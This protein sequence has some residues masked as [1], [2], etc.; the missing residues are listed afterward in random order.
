MYVAISDGY[1][2]AHGNQGAAA[3][4]TFTVDATGPAAPTFAPADGDTAGPGTEI[5]LTFAEALRKDAAGAE[6]ANT[7]LAAILTLKTT[8]ASGTDIA[9]AASIDAAKKVITL[10]PTSD[11]AAGDVY[12]AIS[13]AHFDAHGNQGAAADATFTVDATGPA[14]PTFAPADGDTAGPG[15]EITL[16]FAEALRKDAAGA[17]LANTDL[18]A[19]L[20]LK[21][22]DASGTD[23]AFAASIDA[24]KKVITLDP[25]SDLAAGD[26]YV[27]ISN[28]HFDAHGNQGAAAN[29]TFTVDATGP[30]APTFA[31]AD[32]DTAGPGTD[33]TLTFAEA[34]RKDAAGAELANTDLAAILTL[35]TTDASGTD[36]AF[37]ASIDAAK[38]VITLDP[39]SD[40][41]AGDV[42]VAISN[43]H[44]DAHG[45][46]GAA[47]NATFTVDATGPAA[48]TFAPADGDTA[49][50][51][52]DI[53]LTF[54]EALRKDAAGAELANTDLAAIL[55]LKTT[56]ASGT[57]IAFAASIDAAKK[58]ITL[59]PT[60][61]L[62]AG[63]VYVAISDGYFDAHGN[64]GAAANAT[65]TVDATGPAAPTFAPADGDT[66]GPGT[67]I[68]LTFAEALRKD[69]AGAEL[70]N[71]DLAAILTLK[72]TDASGT[73]IAF[74][75]SIDAA[76]KV[77]TLD[78]TSDLA[79]GDVYVAISN[80][81][82]D[83]HGNQGAAANATFTVDATGPA[84]PTFAPA[85]GDTAGP[86]T[87]ITL[88]FAEA[89]RKDAAG[90]ELA[91]TD[92][93]AILTLKTTDASGTDIAFAASIDAA[94][95]VITL[96]PTSDLAAGDVYVAISNAHFDA[97]GNQGA[98]ANATFTVDA[99]GPAAPTFAPADG[100]TAG[101]GTDITLTFAEALRK[102]AAGAEL[103]NTDLAAIL[104]LKTT[105]ASGTDIAFAASIDAAKKVI[106]LD[107][108]SDLAAGD[109][110]V[111]ISDG[112]FD[113]H[114]NQGAAAEATFT[115]DATGPA[116]PTFAPADG[117]TAGP[118]TDITLTFAEALRKD[119]DGAELANAD[120]AAILTLKT[121]DASGTDIAFSATIDAAKKVIT[122]DPTSDLAAGDVYVAISDG[123]FDAHGNQGAAASA[124]FTVDA[125]GPAAPTFAPADGATAGPGTDITLTF[126][127]ALRKDAAGAELANTDLAAILTLKTTDASGTDI[128][129]AASIDAAKKVITLDPTSDLAAGDVYV[130][131]SNAHFDA[132][133][134]QGAAANATFT[135]D[136][137]GPAAPTFAPA[138]G[139][140]AGPGTDITLTFAEALRKDAAGAELANT[141]LAAILTL[142]TTDASGTDIAFAA[143]ID[144]A[145]KVITLDPTSD[146]AAGDVY[147]AISDA[148]F[149]AHGNQGAAANATF[150]VDATGPAAPTFA[151]ADG[152]TA[153]PGTDITLTFAEALRKDAAGAELANTDLA[154]ILTLKTTNASGTD[155]AFSAS[156]DAAKK[157]I[158]LDPSSR[159]SPRA[160]CTWRSRT[161]TSTRTATRVRRP[162]P[163]S[164]WTPAVRRRRRSPR[165]TATPPAR[166]RTSR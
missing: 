42:Y 149:D 160:T 96:D 92:L 27:A 81:H 63:D 146:L 119:A 112:Y 130:A 79:A 71:T 31:P 113:A 118:G 140:T 104:T 30:A 100:D 115:V 46:Q 105:D 98:A 13:N 145:K 139:D 126:A 66:A 162:T 116:A 75:A 154:A 159:P 157:V 65:F 164:R 142:K 48:P 21:T 153:G 69:A 77:I 24:A 144:A 22:T 4:A 15:T 133:G 23:I 102:D 25:T 53:T 99:T 123:Y 156:I 32:G 101:P 132:H 91:N 109:V 134:N 122:L 64:Q 11:L 136:A 70:A 28:A 17:E 148:H 155:I 43:A 103:A 87:E 55:T 37:S 12:V 163:P 106:T 88:T 50:P 35:K 158:T 45:N 124:T 125:T 59:D 54:A 85:D 97:H 36:I 80:A 57:D 120:L 84:A 72:T 147:V 10:D 2:D 61:D 56:D 166:A 62:A 52:T 1:F 107:P 47:A 143:S 111:A 26:V 6:L 38:K 51:G 29:A 127:E 83:A 76:K 165:P 74:A 34:L 9:F 129:F 94:K 33:I 137:T 3:N 93:A 82:F 14:A 128:A 110:Y 151:P 60:S 19:I 5:T 161:A 18:A 44:F 68:T 131:I 138:D 89:L 150:T 40:L 152:D 16:T 135:V 8:D 58:V 41:A 7:D 121:T 39:T 95:K 114:G 67:D 86:G 20:T 49:G 141:D 78:P 73:D 108:T 117:D 90:A